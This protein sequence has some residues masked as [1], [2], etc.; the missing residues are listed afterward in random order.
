MAVKVKLVGL[1]VKLAAGAAV[2]VSVTVID[3]GVFVAPEPEMAM[4]EE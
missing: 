4:V 2:K 1:T 3:W